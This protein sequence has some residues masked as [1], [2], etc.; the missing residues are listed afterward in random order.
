MNTKILARKRRKAKSRA[1]GIVGTLDIPRLAFFR[2][3]KNVYAQLID[4]AKGNTLV[5]VS[6]LKSTKN[7]ME[8]SVELGVEIAKKAKE[9]KIGK[10]VFDKGGF[11]YTG[12]VK[13][14]ADSARNGGLIF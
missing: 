11:L 14:F 3:N 9:K 8:K 10:V 6:S 13:A 5:G 2:S 4:D 1:K 12:N 7:G